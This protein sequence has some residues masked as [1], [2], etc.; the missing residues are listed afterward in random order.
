MKSVALKVL[1]ILIPLLFI[2]SCASGSETQTPTPT[3]TTSFPA[4]SAMPGA[5]AGLTV[6]F[7]CHQPGIYGA[8]KFPAGHEGSADTVEFCSACHKA[9]PAATNTPVT[10]KTAPS[11]TST[12]ATTSTQP[13]GTTTTTAPAI[14]TTTVTTTTVPATTT[15]APSGAPLAIPA[16]HAGRPVCLVCHSSGIGGAPKVP[17]VPSHASFTD[18]VAFCQ[19][20]HKGP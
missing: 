13:A 7:I 16:S 6:C 11:T 2:A 5:H 15:T 3:P 4:P 14:T 12:P 10:T 18:S 17:A 8:P 9:P 1:P 20:C 19:T